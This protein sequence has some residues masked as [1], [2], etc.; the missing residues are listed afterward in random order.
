MTS[1]T[2]P[3]VDASSGIRNDSNMTLREMWA[4]K[5]AASWQKSIDSI[6]ETGR[7]LIAAKEEL[8]HGEW[9]QM[10]KNELPFGDRTAEM[11]IKVAE[12]PVLSDSNHGSNLPASWRTLYELT[13]LPKDLLERKIESGEITPRTER[14]DVAAMRGKARKASAAARSGVVRSPKVGPL[15]SSTQRALEE[16]TDWIK[17]KADEDDIPVE[18]I[19][20][21]FEQFESEQLIAMLRT[22]S[23]DEASN[24]SIESV[25][26]HYAAEVGYLKVS[27]AWENVS[28]EDAGFE[29]T[30]KAAVKNP[31]AKAAP[32]KKATPKKSATKKPT[33]TPEEVVERPEIRDAAE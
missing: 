8:E 5:I 27:R 13:K 18:T 2:H 9:L 3:A 33:T 16:T 11:L 24:R 25:L 19:I 31:K 26:R 22:G 15:N 32:K 21:W 29:R 30:S 23:A 10:V 20:S 14:K 12:N 6:L 7:N 4:E 17:S 28:R 1:L